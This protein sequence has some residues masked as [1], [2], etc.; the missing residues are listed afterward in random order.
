MYVA[1]V[2]FVRLFFVCPLGRPY[3]VYSTRR[4]GTYKKRKRLGGSFFPCGYTLPPCPFFFL[5]AGRSFRGTRCPTRF[6][7][8]VPFLSASTLLLFLLLLLYLRIR[9]S[10]FP[11]RAARAL[12]LC[13][14]CFG[15]SGRRDVRTWRRDDEEHAFENGREAIAVYCSVEK[16]AA[17]CLVWLPLCFCV[18]AIRPGPG[19]GLHVVSWLLLF[20]L[21]CFFFRASSTSLCA[22]R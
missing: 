16:G 7:F 6:L 1:Y 11:K 14:S 12:T 18:G 5:A 10:S 15:R 8:L 22:C 3:N 4:R 9:E 20:F 21:S 19:H 13:Y 17:C 2:F